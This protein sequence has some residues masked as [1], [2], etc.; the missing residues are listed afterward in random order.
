MAQNTPGSWMR[1]SDSTGL[2]YSF[3][4]VEYDNAYHMLLPEMV[5]FTPAFGT[6]NEILTKAT[7]EF[8][9]LIYPAK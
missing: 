4:V 1:L 3:K 2:P 9:G 5:S 7:F 8:S 6:F